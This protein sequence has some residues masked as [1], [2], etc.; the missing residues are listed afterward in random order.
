MGPRRLLQ[1]RI[2]RSTWF[3]SLTLGAF[4]FF[5]LLN[6]A[7]WWPRPFGAVLYI[8]AERGA[9]GIAWRTGPPPQDPD[10]HGWMIELAATAPRSAKWVPLSRS[11][12][13]P[14]MYRAVW[15]PL[16]VPWLLLAASSAWFLHRDRRARRHL[17]VIAVRFGRS[18]RTPLASAAALFRPR[19]GLCRSCGYDLAG[20]QDGAPCPECGRSR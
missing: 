19:P 2:N 10:A 14:E 13:S 6:D 15:I 5:W 17:G 4:T 3:T 20:L 7:C 8:G 1:R 16:W 18:C 9:A 12:G 11:F